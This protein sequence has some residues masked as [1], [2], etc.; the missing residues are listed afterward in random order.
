M[1][2]ITKLTL[3]LLFFCV[4]SQ[5][6]NTKMYSDADEIRATFIFHIANFTNFPEQVL[7]TQ[8]LTFCFLEDKHNSIQQEFNIANIT[9]LQSLDVVGVQISA[10]SDLQKISCQLLFVGASKESPELFAMLKVLNNR[11]VSIGE[12]RNFLK[13]GGL[14]SLEEK[15]SR[16]QIMVN[17]TLY[18]NSSMKFR[19]SLLKHAKF[20]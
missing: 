12:T 9:K 7:I 13:K 4:A 10:Y 6:N 16:I 17:K 5:A 20:H 15:K 3:V 8:K 1:T 14:I 19:S 11:T 18:A 2:I